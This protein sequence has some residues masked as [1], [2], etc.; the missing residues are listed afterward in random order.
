VAINR[1]LEAIAKGENRLLLVMATGT[2]KTYVAFQIIWRLWKARN[3]KRVLFLADRNILVDQTRN[4]D[5]KPFGDKMTKIMHR[6]ADKSYE[7][8]LALYQ[9]LTGEE[10]WKNIYRE[11]SRDFFD[12]VIVDECHR[13]SAAEDSAWREI[14]EYFSPA[15]QI[16]MTATP[17]ETQTVSNME[18][19][20]QP[21]YLYSLR[22]GIED[23]FLAPY[24]VVRISIDK[25]VEGW[26]PPAGKLDKYGIPVPDR[27]YDVKDFDRYLVIDERTRLV[28]RKV[29]EYLKKTNR[30]DKT[31]VF[32]VDIEHA[33]RMRQAL[34]NENSDLAGPNPKYVMRITGDS[35]EGKRELD[36]FIDPESAY[37]VVVTTSELLTTGVDAQTCKLIVLDSNIA[38]MTKFKQIIGRGTRIRED[39]HKY[40]FTILDFRKVTNLFADPDFDGEPV[41]IYEPEGDDDIVPPEDDSIPAS[42]GPKDDEETSV[43][44]LYVNG[45]HVSILHERVQYYGP[46]GRLITES[47]KDYTRKTLRKRY[48]SLD[49][50]LR[51]WNEAEK[52]QAVLDELEEQGISCAS[53]EEEIGLDR[54]SCPRPECKRRTEGRGFDPFDLIC[55]I[56]Y[57]KPPLTRRERANQVRKRDYFTRYQ[58]KARAVLDALLTK[59]ADEGIH[60]LESMEILQIP[61]IHQ[62]GAPLELIQSFGGR[63]QYLAAIQELKDCLYCSA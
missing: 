15:T 2:G 26:R 39:Y 1:V 36:S 53:L 8:Y 18:Y 46:D 27:I 56:V 3:K 43:R 5:F 54:G 11:F 52:K 25:D 7:I 29:T 44:K 6:R 4:N 38:S 10:E 30:Y 40:Y 9:G 55:H 45:V 20:G 24:K 17:K 60:D 41:Q 31:I 51:R 33:E 59:Y 37:P 22:Q 61:P 47:L 42:Y 23:G 19:F 35:E 62:I 58:G 12:L 21:I 48:A 13:G 32:C 49:D 14:L 34:V 28:A 16:G 57:D 50:F 63:V